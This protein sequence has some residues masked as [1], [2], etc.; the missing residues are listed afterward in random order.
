MNIKNLFKNRF[1]LTSMKNDKVQ[2]INATRLLTIRNRKPL[3]QLFYF[4]FVFKFEL[5]FILYSDRVGC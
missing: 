3:L 5:R 4:S 2:T 1:L